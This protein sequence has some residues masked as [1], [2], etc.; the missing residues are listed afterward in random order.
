[1]GLFR[2]KP[3]LAAQCC[4]WV[5]RAENFD[6]LWKI[7][8]YAK[9]PGDLH[10]L[11]KEMF[12]KIDDLILYHIADCFELFLQ[13]FTKMDGNFKKSC[14]F[15]NQSLTLG[16]RTKRIFDRSTV[17]QQFWDAN[18]RNLMN[19]TFDKITIDAGMFSIEQLRDTTGL[20]LSDQLFQDL[21]RL[22][23]AAR[24]RY[25]S[26][27]GSGSGIKSFFQNLKKFRK[28]LSEPVQ[29]FIP[30]NIVKYSDN[31]ET[32]INYSTACKLNAEWKTHFLSNE[33]RIFSYKLVNNILGYNV[34]TS[35]FVPGMDRNCTFCNLIRNP[36]PEDETALHLFF[37]CRVSETLI[38]NFFQEIVGTTVSRQEFFG[39][40]KRANNHPNVI[41]YYTCLLI[42]K[43]LWD[44]K[45]RTVLPC[46]TWLQEYVFSE[47][48]TCTS[49]S[50]ILKNSIDRCI[51][52]DPP[53]QHQ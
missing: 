17:G 16:L 39:F 41:L 30:H 32:V 40:A 33:C 23:S 52:N 6:E 19:L 44:C 42:K 3:F 48:K 1:L 35:H 31:T 34:V 13:G 49:I 53:T 10:F 47:L 26:Q 8:L 12:N 14:I 36:D 29:K 37:A 5:K 25:G 21:T 18:K 20:D 50:S 43:F 46:S 2:I 9:T 11:R 51:C 4:A 45:Q 27:T 22:V 38:N 24:T 28:Y 7:N 15:N